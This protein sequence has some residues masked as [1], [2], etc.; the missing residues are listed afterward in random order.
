MTLALLPHQSTVLQQVEL[1]LKEVAITNCSRGVLF[2][3]PSGSGKT[4]LFKLLEERMS[5][6]RPNGQLHVPFCGISLGAASDPATILRRILARLGKPERATR[7]CSLADLE[8]QVLDAMDSCKVEIL[9]I[10][11]FHNALLKNEAT[12]RARV[13]RLIKH[14]WNADNHGKRVILISGTEEILKAFDG[15]DELN[16]RFSNRVYAASLWF[17]SPEIT[18]HFPGVAESIA[19][20]YGVSRLI[21]LHDNLMLSR[22]LFACR[23]HL[24]RL[25]SLCARVST[26]EPTLSTDGNASAIWSAAFLQSVAK[27][28]SPAEDPFSW[29]DDELRH[30]IRAQMSSPRP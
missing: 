10:E 2:I 25:D 22:L 11:E 26:L 13:N 1:A 24:R 15:D 30:R 3:G 8:S 18:A 4:F 6:T 20:R 12:L 28:K 21:D 16:S 9:A 29:S 5:S 27:A 19:A 7:S 17:S 23:G 14:L